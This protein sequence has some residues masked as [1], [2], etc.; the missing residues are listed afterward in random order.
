MHF[1]YSHLDFF[2]ENLGTV[3]NKHGKCFHQNIGTLIIVKVFGPRAGP[4]L[5]AQEPWLQLCRKGVFHRKLRDLGCSF[6]RDE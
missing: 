5:Q 3:N 4:S 2:T 1:L 6:T